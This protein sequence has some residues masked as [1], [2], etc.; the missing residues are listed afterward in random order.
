LESALSSSPASAAAARIVRGSI[1]KVAFRQY[2]SGIDTAV[3]DSAWA[4]IADHADCAN[5]R[6]LAKRLRQVGPDAH[7]PGNPE[8]P[9]QLGEA[10]LELR[11]KAEL[12][13]E[14]YKPRSRFE[15]LFASLYDV[16]ELAAGRTAIS[17]GG[18]VEFLREVLRPIKLL[19]QEQ[20]K[21]YIRAERRRRNILFGAQGG[22]AVSTQIL[23][24]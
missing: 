17:T 21:R 8:W 15:R 20:L 24:P 5:L 13:A 14:I 18:L 22:L 4:R 19:S 7:D 11:S 23:R 1:F 3:G 9:R 6:K 2:R 16:W 12:R 10:L